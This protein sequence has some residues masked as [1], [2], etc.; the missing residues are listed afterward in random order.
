MFY[1][2]DETG[3]RVAYNS[4]AEQGTERIRELAKKYSVDYV[5]T[6]EY[7]PLALPVVYANSYYTIY[8][9]D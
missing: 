1:Y 6:D 5:L 4:L 2:T 3:E 7:P 9:I 8:A